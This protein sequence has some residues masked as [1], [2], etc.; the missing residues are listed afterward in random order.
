MNIYVKILN[1]TYSNQII[2]YISR[3]INYEKQYLMSVMQGYFNI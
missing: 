3:K 2:K 1:K